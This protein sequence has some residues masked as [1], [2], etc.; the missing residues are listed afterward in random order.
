MAI[1]AENGTGLSSAQCYCDVAYLDAYLTERGITSTATT[2]QKEA[3]LV[4]SAK[5]WID[6]Q[7]EFI[8]EKLVSTQS[9]KFPRSGLP[10]DIEYPDEIKLANAKAGYLQLQ[11]LLLVDS[12]LISTTGIVESESKGLGPLSKS[13]T[14]KSGSSQIYGRI[15]PKDLTNLLIPY[16]DTSGLMGTVKRG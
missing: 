3:A 1:I 11:G 9:M 12:S 10:D 5:D 13:V 6:G 7:H 8:G 2:A 16:L 15:L 14:Y 4:I